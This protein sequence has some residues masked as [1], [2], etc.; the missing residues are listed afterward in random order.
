MSPPKSSV[1]DA[2]E[3]LVCRDVGRGT[4]ALIEASRGE[5]AAAARSL[6]HAT[7]IGFITGFFVPRDGVAAPETDGPVGTA[8]L[9]AALG[10]CGEAVRIAVDSPCADAVRAAVH[11]TGV[12]VAVDEMGVKDRPGIE[13][14][15]AV[16]RAAKISHAV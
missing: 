6:I 13:R 4:Q 14:V 11:E 2:V 5:L 15:A 16:W 7:G 12:E 9:A 10:A 8:L 3:A 1:L